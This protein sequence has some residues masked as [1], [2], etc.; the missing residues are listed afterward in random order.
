[1][2][3]NMFCERLKQAR[4]DNQLLQIDVEIATGVNRTSLS[5]YETGQREPDIET[6]GKLANYYG[7]SLDWLFGNVKKDTNNNQGGIQDEQ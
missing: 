5:R 3:K 6:I 2:Y 7:V 1:M 4:E